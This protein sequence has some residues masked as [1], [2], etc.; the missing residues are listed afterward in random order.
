MKKPYCYHQ[1]TNFGRNHKFW[2]KTISFNKLPHTYSF[3]YMS[4]FKTEARTN[5]GHNLPL[6]I[7]KLH[8]CGCDAHVCGHVYDICTCV[9]I[10]IANM[11]HVC[12]IAS[13]SGGPMPDHLLKALPPSV[14]AWYC[15]RAGPPCDPKRW[16]I[17]KRSRC[18]R[19]WW[20]F[21]LTGRQ[22]NTD[23]SLTPLHVTHT[24]NTLA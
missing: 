9:L 14:W 5:D 1:I 22:N 13:T 6:D 7:L 23:V 8:V 10:W 11:M 4:W 12:A 15:T 21:F 18:R 19:A 24:R 3:C 17:P 20:W 16:R 2:L